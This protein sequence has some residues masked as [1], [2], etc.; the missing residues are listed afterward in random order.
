MFKRGLEALI[1]DDFPAC[2]YWLS[3]G[4]R[5]NASNQ[6]LNQDMKQIIQRVHLTVS[7]NASE[8]TARPSHEVHTDF[9]LYDA[10]KL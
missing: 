6:A 10:K 1:R 2:I 4:I 9:S 8:K 5:A 3:A 7:D